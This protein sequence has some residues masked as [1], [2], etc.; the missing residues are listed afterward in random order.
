MVVQPV[1]KLVASFDV[2]YKSWTHCVTDRYH[3]SCW[4]KSTAESL[5]CF[6]SYV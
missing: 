2:C 1:L 5:Y 4:Q 6:V 3:L